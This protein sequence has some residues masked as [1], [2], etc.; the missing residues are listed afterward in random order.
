MFEHLLHL[1]PEDL[2]PILGYP[3]EVVVDVVLAVES[4]ADCCNLDVQA[5][6][7]WEYVIIIC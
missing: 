2:S 7:V 5:V 1:A 3:D 4:P 6:F